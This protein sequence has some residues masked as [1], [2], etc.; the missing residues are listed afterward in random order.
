LALELICVLAHQIGGVLKTFVCRRLGKVLKLLAKWRNV[1]A[2]LLTDGVS[3]A[4]ARMYSAFVG[5]PWDPE[6]VTV[7]MDV[8]VVLPP[9][10]EARAITAAE[11]EATAT[12]LIVNRALLSLNAASLTACETMMSRAVRARAVALLFVS[13]WE[14]DGKVALPIRRRLSPSIGC[15][16]LP[17]PVTPSCRKRL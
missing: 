11:S 5:A 4:D 14:T 6:A 3:L 12:N 7:S 8:V 2:A 17:A 13:P 10:H 9:P 1:L 15:W 16:R